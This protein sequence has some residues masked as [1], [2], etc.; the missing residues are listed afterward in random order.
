MSRSS[1]TMATV[2]VCA[3]G[4]DDPAAGGCWP[5]NIGI[6]VLSLQYVEAAGSSPHSHVGMFPLVR[7]PLLER[8]RKGQDGAASRGRHDVQAA[9]ERLGPAAHAEQA[10]AVAHG[11]DVES[12]ASTG[13]LQEGAPLV[14]PELQ[15][16]LGAAGMPRQ[17]GDR[18]LEQEEQFAPDVRAD[19]DVA[20]R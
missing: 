1:S 18:F 13:D 20:L 4:V 17:V 2:R 19:R 9:A 10:V 11:A 3:G 7:G 5:G 15:V 14:L 6:I 16:G 12:A 8:N